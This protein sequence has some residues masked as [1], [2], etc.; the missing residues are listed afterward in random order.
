MAIGILLLPHSW[1][2]GH[3]A[4]GPVLGITPHLLKCSAAAVMKFLIIFNKALSVFILHRFLQT[5]QRVLFPIPLRGLEVGWGF[6]RE[7]A[8]TPGWRVWEEPWVC[9]A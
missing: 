8:R 9:A 2:C 5:K 4:W 3:V 7:V 6:P 1:L